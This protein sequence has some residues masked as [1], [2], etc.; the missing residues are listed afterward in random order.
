[1]HQKVESLNE[2]RFINL[3]E[4][5]MIYNTAVSESPEEEAINPVIEWV[6]TSGLDGASR[7][8]GSNENPFHQEKVRFMAMVCMPLFPKILKRLST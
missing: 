8:F 5:R 3:P 6:K 2:V 1:M 7:L 4:M